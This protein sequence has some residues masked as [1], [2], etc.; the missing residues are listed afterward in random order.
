MIMLQKR[1]D[2]EKWLG[3][4]TG[5]LRAQRSGGRMSHQG[6]T[7]GYDVQGVI[8]ATAIIY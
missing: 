5:L 1:F 3:V 7:E 2:S 6:G 4:S 8:A